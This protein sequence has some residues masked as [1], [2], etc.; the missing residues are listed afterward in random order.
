MEVNQKLYKLLDK[1]NNG[2]DNAVKS[3]HSYYSGKFKPIQT[4]YSFLNELFF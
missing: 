1:N 2:I 3:I 4:S